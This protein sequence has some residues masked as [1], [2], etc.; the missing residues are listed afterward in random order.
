MKAVLVALAVAGFIV[1][2]ALPSAAL[3][4]KS[5]VPSLASAAFGWQ[6]TTTFRDGLRTTVNWYRD[7]LAMPSSMYTRAT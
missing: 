5:A 7:S 4:E 1:A 2:L 6:S 3:D